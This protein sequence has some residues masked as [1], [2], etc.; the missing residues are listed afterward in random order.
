M[1]HR[2]E[3]R[4]WPGKHMTVPNYI[5]KF[6][7]T[8]NENLHTPRRVMLPR[9]TNAYCHYASFSDN[10]MTNSHSHI[11][12]ILVR[13]DVVIRSNTIA[14]FMMTPSFDSLC[15]TC[16]YLP[17]SINGSSVIRSMQSDLLDWMVFCGDFLVWQTLFPPLW[18][19]YLSSQVVFIFL[20]NI[21]KNI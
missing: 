5:E 20:C 7:S 4:C 2:K 16:W 1:V 9:Y 12:D 8:M 11:S 15:L 13:G 3:T 19:V 6:I 14:Y 21:I 10:R 18:N 17:S